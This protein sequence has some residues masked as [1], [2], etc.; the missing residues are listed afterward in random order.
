MPVPPGWD[1]QSFVET[2]WQA[3][4]GQFLGIDISESKVIQNY[5]VSQRNVSNA[6]F[7]EHFQKILYKEFLETCHSPGCGVAIKSTLTRRIRS[8][9]T[10]YDIDFVNVVN[11]DLCNNSLDSISASD[12]AKVIKTWLNGWA[13]T[14]RIKED[15]F[16]SCFLGCM[17]KPDS[18]AHYLM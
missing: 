9:F 18:L 3:S 14:Y 11:L 13:T 1:S 2:L 6:I 8:L 5:E 15:F 10:P 17:D 4:C 12:R 16:H 7:H